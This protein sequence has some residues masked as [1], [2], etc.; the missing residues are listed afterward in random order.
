MFVLGQAISLLHPI[1]PFVTEEIYQDLPF[2][3]SEDAYLIGAQWPSAAALA[4]YVDDDAER[5]IDL[6]CEVISAVRSTRARYRL[7]PRQAL[8]V[9][10]KAPGADAALL[11]AQRTLVEGMGNTS[12]LSVAPDAV[13]PDASAVVLGEGV[14]T[15]I[16]LTGLVDFD[17]ERAR[18]AKER[19][20]VAKDEAKLAKKL[21]NQGFLAK[22]AP[23]I[24]EKDR[25]H[26]AELADMLARID[27]QLAE[28]A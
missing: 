13:K 4:A 19:D 17:A 28:L 5:A 14:E 7:S 21:S 2:D 11:D 20:K 10:V 24:I 6:V 27:A 25:A 15:Y 18:L 9:V 22:A 3:R 26:H 1:M 23:E 12:S 16:A 8:D